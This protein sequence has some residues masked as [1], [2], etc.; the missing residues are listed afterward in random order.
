MVAKFLKHSISRVLSYDHRISGSN[1]F[2]FATLYLDS[3][4]RALLALGYNQV[5]LT[6]NYPMCI[7]IS[8]SVWRKKNQLIEFSEVVMGG[9]G[10]ACAV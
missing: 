4:L 1:E 9:A 3:R 2:H 7:Q 5:N 10:G 6:C 8:P